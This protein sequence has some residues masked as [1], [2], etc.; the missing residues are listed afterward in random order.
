MR[1]LA[2][3]RTCPAPPASSHHRK[4]LRRTVPGLVAAALVGGIVLVFP[5]YAQTTPADGTLKGTVIEAPRGAPRP[6][7][8]VT[9]VGARR[10]GTDPMTRKVVTDSLG[11]FTFEGL[12]TGRSRVYAVQAAFDGG[13]FAGSPI[14]IPARTEAAPVIDSTLRVWA[15]TSDPAAIVVKR[16]AIFLAPSGDSLGVIE[17]VVVENTSRRAYIGRARDMGMGRGPAPEATPTLGFSLP[18]GA[19]GSSVVLVDASWDGPSP[20]ATDFGFGA[21]VA[22]PPGE[23]S[24][25]FSYRT[26]GSGGVFDASRTALYPTSELVVHAVQPLEVEGNRLEADGSV[27]VAGRTYRRWTAAGGIEAGDIVQVS[28]TARAGLDLPLL[29]GVAAGLALLIAAGMLASARRKRSRP[30]Q[31]VAPAPAASPRASRVPPSASPSSRAAP[32]ASSSAAHSREEVIATIAALDL[33]HDSGRL[34]DEEWRRR[35]GAL[36]GLLGG[37]SSER[38]P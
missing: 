16:H 27:R 33:D 11:R 4:T 32:S 15:T 12:P 23:T 34:G 7:V 18:S 8:R 5:A 21:T 20:I 13:I 17:S 28:A 14:Q 9:L 30:A 25:T 6:G 37:S 22:I 35:R 1:R 31:P 36:K 24:T 26:T 38:T 29:A 3:R 10:D 2:A 19:D